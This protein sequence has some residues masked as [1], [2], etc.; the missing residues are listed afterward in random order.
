MNLKKLNKLLKW[1]KVGI[2][3]KNTKT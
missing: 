1:L 3:K 2:T